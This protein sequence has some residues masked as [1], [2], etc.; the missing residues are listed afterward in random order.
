MSLAKIKN[1]RKERTRKIE[2]LKQ[3]Q[4]QLKNDDMYSDEYKLQ[5][6]NEIRKS[7]QSIRNEYDTQI[8]DLIKQEENRLLQG[9]HN[10][11]YE[12]LKGEKATVELLKEMRNQQ[13]A[14]HL[15]S[16]YKGTDP[17]QVESVLYSEAKRLVSINSPQAPAYINAFK[18]LGV[19]GAE[20]LEQ[21]YKDKNLND[22]Q[23]SYK[24]DLDLI[25]QQKKEFEVEI[26]EENDPLKG[27]LMQHY[28]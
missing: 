17:K 21:E 10:A 7:L 3:Q 13:Q 18:Q 1:L 22:L 14:E 20:S 24:S 23:R 27:A 6:N 9:F 2:L 16:K 25:R 28:M 5:K 12:D 11:E 26:A 15:I 8:N 4:E 19:S